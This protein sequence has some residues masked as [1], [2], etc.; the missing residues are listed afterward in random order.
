MVSINND[1]EESKKN[2][3]KMR[4]EFLYLG[5]KNNDNN[6]E[7]STFIVNEAIKITNNFKKLMQD[8]IDENNKTKQQVNMLI[9]DRVKLQQ[10]TL[11][12]EN[13]IFEFEKDLGYKQDL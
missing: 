3:Q 2:I 12:L 11:V 13:R 10:E 4:G 7:M 5:F 1:L 9:Q 6:S 8:E